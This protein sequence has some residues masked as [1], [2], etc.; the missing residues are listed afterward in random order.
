MDWWGYEWVGGCVCICTCRRADGLGGGREKEGNM[1]IK[2]KGHVGPKMQKK[3]L[4]R[5]NNSR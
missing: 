2:E 4:N 3:K 5:E 1:G